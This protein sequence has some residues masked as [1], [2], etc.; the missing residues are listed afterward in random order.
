MRVSH[1]LNLLFSLGVCLFFYGCTDP[2]KNPNK[3]YIAFV[4]GNII[5]GTGK[6]AIIDGVLLM[7][8]G[9]VVAVGTQEDIELPENTQIIDIQDKTVIPGLINSHAHVGYEQTMQPENYSKEHI[10]GQ[11]A[12]YARYGITT[13]VSLGEDHKEA[14]AYRHA[15]DTVKVMERARLYI[16]GKIVSGDTIREAIAEVDDKVKMGVDFMKIRVDDNLGTT[17]KMRE[18]VYQT[19]INRSH[20]YNLKLAAHMYYLEDA[21]NLLEAG[22][23]FLAH[24]VRDQK[25]DAKLIELLNAKKVCYCPTLTRDLS[26]FIYEDEPAFFAD[27]FFLHEV[28]S[29]TLEMLKDTAR[30]TS[31]SENPNNETYKAA[32]QMAMDNLKILS[33]SGVTIA[34]GTDSG[35]PTRFQGYFEHLEMAMMA[36]AGMSPMQILVSATQNPARCLGLKDVGTLEKGKWADFVI[37]KDDPLQDIKNT[38]SIDAVYIGGDQIQR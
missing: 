27:P 1:Q 12:L 26:T 15:V 19:I 31:V 32:L 6:P 5:E 14:V 4:G 34:L 7:S 22:A 16:A 8:E 24:S 37:L 30:Q 38:R 18:E 3:A 33:D 17:D 29:L 11:L 20:D 21:K 28:D 10:L 9:R 36:E 13:V 23:D 25:V 35:V 2:E